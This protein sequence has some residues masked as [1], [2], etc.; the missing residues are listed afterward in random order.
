MRRGV[1]ARG[2]EEEKELL[3]EEEGEGEYAA[4][5]AAVV[6]CSSGGG[7]E[8]LRVGDEDPEGGRELLEAEEL[9]PTTAVPPEWDRSRERTKGG[10]RC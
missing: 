8:A 1:E 5:P 7:R 6:V 9:P 2:E 10:N 4:K 3:R